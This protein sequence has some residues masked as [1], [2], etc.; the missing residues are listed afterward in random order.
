MSWRFRINKKLMNQ[1]KHPMQRFLQET[2][3][4]M[5]YSGM[6]FIEHSPGSFP[7]RVEPDYICYGVDLKEYL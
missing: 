4:D 6:T 7:K 1:G 3:I 2:I 5:M